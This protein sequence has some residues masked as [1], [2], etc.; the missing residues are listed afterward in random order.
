MKSEVEVN[1]CSEQLVLRDGESLAAYIDRVD[2]R[3]IVLLP[4]I[5]YPFAD[6]EKYGGPAPNTSTQPRAGGE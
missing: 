4:G 3:P 6:H 5:D 2:P 1:E